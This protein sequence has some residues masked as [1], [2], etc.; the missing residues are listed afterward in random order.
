MIIAL[1]Y[2][3]IKKITP[4]KVDLVSHFFVLPD[5]PGQNKIQFF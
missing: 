3:Y 1:L 4:F 2:M 5:A